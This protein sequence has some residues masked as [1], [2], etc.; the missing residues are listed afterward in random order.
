M[1]KKGNT[2]DEPGNGSIVTLLNPNFFYLSRVII[3]I[4]KQGFRLVVQ[5]PTQT[6]YDHFYDSERGAKIAFSKFFG[7]HYFRKRLKDEDE[8]KKK[9]LA[10]WS[11]NYSPEWKKWKGMRLE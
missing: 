6:L 7:S 1:D 10:Q 3:K 11:H 5:S 2:R 4:E 9:F 8:D